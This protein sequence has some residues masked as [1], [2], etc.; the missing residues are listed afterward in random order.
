MN[1]PHPCTARNLLVE[2]NQRT[3]SSLMEKKQHSINFFPVDFC[4]EDMLFLKNLCNVWGVL[5]F[6]E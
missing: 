6:S 1:Y 2:A 4:L 3:F 5:F